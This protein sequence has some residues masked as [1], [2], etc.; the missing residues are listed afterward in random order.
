VVA[1]GIVIGIFPD[2]FPEKLGSGHVLHVI[3]IPGPL[4]VIFLG[5]LEPDHVLYLGIGHERVGTEDDRQYEK[6]PRVLNGITLI[7][8][9][10]RIV[11]SAI[12][13]F[14]LQAI[15]RFPL[16]FIIVLFPA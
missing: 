6:A 12:S 9:K 4:A 8:R 2:R 3:E 7:H 14:L 11:F 13:P 16:L 15:D 5:D 10:L 1:G